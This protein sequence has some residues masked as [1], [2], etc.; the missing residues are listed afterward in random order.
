[1]NIFVVR[2]W[3]KSFASWTTSPRPTPPVGRTRWRTS[4]STWAQWRWSTSKRT[5]SLLYLRLH[6][7]EA[8]FS[9]SRRRSPRPPSVS[10]QG[11]DL[12]PRC[13]A[14][15]APWA[16]HARS[17]PCPTILVRTNNFRLYH[18]SLNFQLR[19]TTRKWAP[20]GGRWRRSPTWFSGRGSEGS[21]PG[22]RNITRSSMRSNG[23]YKCWC[24]NLIRW[25]INNYFL[26]NWRPPS[27]RWTA[28]PNR[29]RSM[30]AEWMTT[31]R[32]LR[33]IREN[34]EPSLRWVS[35]LTGPGLLRLQRLASYE[36]PDWL[37][38]KWQA[39]ALAETGL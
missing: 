31:T 34:L 28:R 33:R 18:N 2:F 11:S 23:E 24:K 7:S 25:S 37:R 21:G 6:I 17:R 19:M 1:M 36:P 20:P 5:S 16:L 10:P 22:W 29:C 4:C 35:L 39:L 26:V 12:T 3:T 38:L 14:E 9:S 30:R 27:L 13:P 8:T 15:P 32:S